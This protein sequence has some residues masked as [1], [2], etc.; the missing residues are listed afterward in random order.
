MFLKVQFPVQLSNILAHATIPS[1]K[2]TQF[3]VWTFKGSKLVPAWWLVI[4][5]GLLLFR[6]LAIWSLKRWASL[7]M[8]LLVMH[9]FPKIKKRATIEKTINIAEYWNTVTCKM[10]KHKAWLP[11]QTLNVFWYASQRIGIDRTSNEIK[12]LV[13]LFCI[14]K[15]LNAP[16]GY[17]PWESEGKDSGCK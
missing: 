17:L 3:S 8:I 15:C 14:S 11:G 12:V 10:E 9:R 1:T 13:W 2:F 4:N 16:L 7:D 5:E 6:L